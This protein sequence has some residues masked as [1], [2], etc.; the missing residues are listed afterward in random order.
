MADTSE[1]SPQADLS[2]IQLGM[3]L[4]RRRWPIWK[5]CYSIFLGVLLG[6]VLLV[7]VF[8]MLDWRYTIS[9]IESHGGHMRRR[10]FAP[11]AILSAAS[12]FLVAN[13][14]SALAEERKK[15]PTKKEYLK[16]VNAMCSQLSDQLDSLTAQHGISQDQQPT[17]DRV[18]AFAK[19]YVAFMRDRLTQ[20]RAITAPKGDR[21]KVAAIFDALVKAVDAVEA[22]PEVLVGRNDPFERA[23]KLARAYGLKECAPQ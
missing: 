17:P 9:T 6:I 16:Q 14:R 2:R 22:N 8:A 20:V 19:D 7:V 18:D 11:I 23:D 1:Q 21:K 15:P 5:V 12:L 4:P 13:P 3:R 10:L